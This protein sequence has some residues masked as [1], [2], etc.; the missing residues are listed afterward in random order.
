C[1]IR[2]NSDDHHQRG[3]WF[4]H[5]LLSN[6]DAWYPQ[7]PATLLVV[8]LVGLY[9]ACGNLLADFGLHL[10]I[11]RF[12]TYQSWHEYAWLVQCSQQPEPLPALIARWLGPKHD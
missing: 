2:L 1:S 11:R 12:H 3:G 7:Y 6:P 9:R 5:A 10:A 4:A 8:R